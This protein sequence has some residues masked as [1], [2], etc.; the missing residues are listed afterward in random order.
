M[1]LSDVLVAL[2][3]GVREFLDDPANVL[4]CTDPVN[5]DLEATLKRL[6]LALEQCA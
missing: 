5:E 3:A 6:A 4:P 1:L 2:Q